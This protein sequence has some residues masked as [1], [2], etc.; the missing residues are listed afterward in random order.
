MLRA[1]GWCLLSSFLLSG[2]GPTGPVR[3]ALY[4]D[5]PSLRRHIEQAERAGKLDRARVAELAHAVAAREVASA[6]GASGVRRVRAVVGCARPMLSALRQRAAVHD[7]PGA[8]AMLVLIGLRDQEPG[9]LVERYGKE[10]SPAW[11][12][13]AAR[14]ALEPRDALARRAWFVDPDERVRRAAF[15][16]ALAAPDA[17]DLEILLESFRLD[18]GPMSRS[19]AAR[20]AGAIGGEASVLGLKDRFARADEAGRLTLIEAWAMP[21]AYRSGGARE[22]RLVAESRQGLLSVAAADAL[23]RSGD[24][25]GALVGLLVTSLEHGSE[26]ERRLAILLAPTSDPRVGA[27]LDRARSDA[28]P[29]VR[30]IAL[31][32]L[33]RVKERAAESAKALR[34]MAARSDGIADQAR[35]ALA[36]T[37]DRSVVPQLL[38]SAQKG[39]PWQRGRAAVALFRLGVTAP[40]AKTLADADPGVRIAASCGILAS[41]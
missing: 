14:A 16:A 11:R 17:S 24:S 21:A 41:R 29:E 35:A 28:N 26:D 20:A 36:A 9:S 13:V 25:D 30:V 6:Q 12:A 5:L 33:L 4:E 32:R 2:C 40:A 37:G 10:A 3:A 15:E 18:P 34:E 23:I 22:L 38:V 7:E 19:L 31:A 8:E 27:A 39:H 1:L